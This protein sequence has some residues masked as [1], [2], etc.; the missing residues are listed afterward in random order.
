MA[1]EFER[2]YYLILFSTILGPLTTNALVP[3]F[4]V[5]KANFL[6]SEVSLVALVITFYIIPFAILQLFAGT[7]S[8]I[9]NKKKV[10]NTG[11]ICF[12]I[13]LLLSLSAVYIT[14]FSLFIIGFLLQGIGFAMINPTVLAIL[15]IITPEPKKGFIMGLYNSSAGIGVSFGALLSG[16]FANLIGE[17]RLIFI[18]N[19]IVTVV[20]LIFFL[21]ATKECEFN[22]CTPILSEKK[23][24]N[25]NKILHAFRASMR[26]LSDNLNKNI[27]IL[28]LAGF[29]TF[30]SI[31]S[32]TNTITEQ[33][34]IS[35]P[36]L[37]VQEVI[38]SVTLILMVNGFIS[39]VL[40]PIIGNL[41]KRVAPLKIMI[42]GFVMMLSILF[43]PYGT[44]LYHY[45]L[46]SGII[47]VGSSFIWPALFK[48][49]MDI[50]QE[51][52]G[53]NSAI[54]NSLRFFG[55]AMV[56]IFYVLI[57]ILVLYILV[58]VLN[59][60]GITLIIYLIKNWGD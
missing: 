43:L 45:I 41:L 9:I 44:S 48:Q 16:F 27:L 49:A 29:F 13:G 38:S 24:G 17:W 15:N 28:G 40:S 54:I 4:D 47:Y 58:F 11:F 50:S 60:L 33:I 31:I 22:I 3:I 51:A 1:E 30:F 52:S 18:F 39:I 36:A 23:S 56:G 12:L 46:L 53:T 20:A 7:I 21:I 26:Q 8:D 42:V 2:K 57:G 6:L 14:N 10:V 37:T 55:Y 59:L 35:I 19:P 32:L 5:L 34:A 25:E